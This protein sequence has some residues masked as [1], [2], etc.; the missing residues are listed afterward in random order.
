MEGLSCVVHRDKA[1]SKGK[2]IIEKLKQYIPRHQFKVVLQAMISTKVGQGQYLQFND[3][4]D[5][6]IR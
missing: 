4:N 3:C 5:I 1:H 6:F 2:E